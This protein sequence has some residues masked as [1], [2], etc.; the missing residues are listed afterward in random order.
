MSK[1][2]DDPGAKAQAA[3][4]GL[5]PPPGQERVMPAKAFLEHLGLAGGLLLVAPR[6][7]DH[8]R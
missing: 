5:P 4:L 6:D 3:H 7:R 2:F 8:G 1:P